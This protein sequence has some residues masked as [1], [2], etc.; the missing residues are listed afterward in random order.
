MH[1][2]PRAAGEKHDRLLTSEKADCS[3]SFQQFP[4][5]SDEFIY[6]FSLL[7]S[8]C[9]IQAVRPARASRPRQSL[10][11]AGPRT[12]TAV[13][14]TS[15][16]AHCGGFTRRAA[17]VFGPASWSRIRIPWWISILRTSPFVEGSGSH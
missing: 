15:A 9:G 16:V 12:G 1:R 8:F 6:V 13:H 3:Q 11:G 17:A 7:P 5:L 14:S 10:R 2:E 4:T